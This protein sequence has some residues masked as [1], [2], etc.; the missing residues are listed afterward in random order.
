[1]SKR[2]SLKTLDVAE[3]FLYK[4]KLEGLEIN[5]LKLQSLT[6]FAKVWFTNSVKNEFS[7]EKEYIDGLFSEKIIMR[8]DNIK[9]ESIYNQYK[10]YGYNSIKNNIKDIPE[11]IK[12]NNEIIPYLNTIWSAYKNYSPKSLEKLITN[13]KNWKKTI[14]P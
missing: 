6:Y 12:E 2:V 9:I 1:M 8:T 5:Y 7:L 10:K 4:A 13:D 14:R 11:N 3:Y